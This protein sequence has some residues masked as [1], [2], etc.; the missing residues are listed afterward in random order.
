M[1]EMNFRVRLRCFPTSSDEESET[2]EEDGSSD[3]SVKE[4]QRA[5]SRPIMSMYS[6]DLI[7]L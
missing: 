5:P 2:S 7:C 6:T 1:T 3:E 4:V